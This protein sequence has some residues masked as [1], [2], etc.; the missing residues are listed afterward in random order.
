MDTV[1][2]HGLKAMWGL[3]TVRPGVS[4]TGMVKFPSFDNI[5]YNVTSLQ[6]FSNSSLQNDFLWQLSFLA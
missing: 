3:F 2:G 4:T 5:F 6:L 1:D